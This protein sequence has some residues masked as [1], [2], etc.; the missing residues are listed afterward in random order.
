MRAASNEAALWII[1]KS[2]KPIIITKE[3]SETVLDAL[4]DDY[5]IYPYSKAIC[6]A[7]MVS[8]PEMDVRRVTM[9]VYE[10]Y[11]TERGAGALGS[12]GK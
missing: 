2:S 1:Y 5:I 8:V 3:T 9:P 7:L 11:S 12:S 4:K 10:M 6:Q